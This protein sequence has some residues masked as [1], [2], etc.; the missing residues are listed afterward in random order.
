M[1]CGKVAWVAGRAKKIGKKRKKKEKRQTIKINLFQ[2]EP[3]LNFLLSCETHLSK[4]KTTKHPTKKTVVA[5]RWSTLVIPA[6]ER[7][8]QKEL[9][10]I[11]GQLEL[12]IKTKASLHYIVKPH[13][14][15]EE[16]EE[17]EEEESSVA[18][19]WKRAGT[20]SKKEKRKRKIGFAVCELQ[21]A[22]QW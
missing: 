20:W 13:L 12:H 5:A 19:P 7:P 10:Q 3:C 18:V 21:S 17:G 14:K 8:R 16:G 6:L 1:D 22:Q 9:L 4:D 11:W 15:E 2:L